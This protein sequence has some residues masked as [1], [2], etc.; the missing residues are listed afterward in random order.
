MSPDQYRP[1]PAYTTLS[2]TYRVPYMAFLILRSNKLIY[3][4]SNNMT[5]PPKSDIEGQ[6]EPETLLNVTYMHVYYLIT[7][8]IVYKVK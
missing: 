6:H 4:H 8:N 2:S 3:Y 7:N 1:T 5:S